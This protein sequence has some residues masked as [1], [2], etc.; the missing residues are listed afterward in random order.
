MGG[1]HGVIF[2]QIFSAGFSSGLSVT[3]LLYFVLVALFY[4]IKVLAWIR[5]RFRDRRHV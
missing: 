3:F 5:R 1:G 4:L 2:M